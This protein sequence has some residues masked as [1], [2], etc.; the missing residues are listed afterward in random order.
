MKGTNDE[1]RVFGVVYETDNDNA[2]MHSHQLYLITWDGKVLHTH[3]FSGV[4]SF[5]V[6]HRHAY[7]GVTDPAPSG[8]P[9]VMRILPS[10]HLMTDMNILFVGELVQQSLCRGVATIT[11]LRV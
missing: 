1:T 8:V 4:T 5:D 11:I 10:R 2:D 9:I 6:G 3:G 7:A